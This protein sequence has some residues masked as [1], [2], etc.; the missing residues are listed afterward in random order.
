MSRL[1]CELLGASEPGFSQLIRDLESAAGQPGVDVRLNADAIHA[2]QAK[3]RALGLDARDTNGRELYHSLRQFV[4]KHDRILSELISGS[5]NHSDD[6]PLQCA[7]T[8]IQK[9]PLPDNCW[10]LKKSSAKN[11]LKNMPPRNLMKQ[12]GYRSIDSL[13]KREN[14]SQI[15]AAINL[16]ESEKWL[17]RFAGSYKLLDSTDFEQRKIEFTVLDGDKW[18]N[19]AAEFGRQQS[20]HI[21]RINIMGIIAG[22]PVSAQP[23][24]GVLLATTA[25]IAYHMQQIR[26]YSAYCK[27]QQ[28]K[29]NF[30][31]LVAKPRL[32]VEVAGQILPWPVLYYHLSNTQSEAL[33]AIFEPHVLPEDF[34][35]QVLANTLGSL[36][37]EFRFWQQTDYLGATDSDGA[38]SYNLLDAAFNYC[39][40]VEY[41]HRSVYYMRESLWYELYS[42]YLTQDP[43]KR[44]ILAQLD[45]NL[46]AAEPA[47]PKRKRKS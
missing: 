2:T 42:R 36:S 28:V 12:L 3:N 25:L 23:P 16:L 5:A 24:T 4:E 34:E 47:K 15:Y 39:N 10:V 44:L 19:A 38:V 29:A 31:E 32:E 13:L 41:S 45:T 20:N 11:I 9:L 22:L 40:N 1:L 35:N 14:I 6:H 37:P 17:K 8:V 21:I 33:A 27:S 18:G 26:S 43:V 46:L 7:L 30:G